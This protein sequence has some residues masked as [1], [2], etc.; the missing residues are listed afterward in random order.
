MNNK[1]RDAIHRVL[2]ITITIICITLAY[3]GLSAQSKGFND[4]VILKNGTVLN[5]VKAVVTKDSLVVTTSEGETSVFTKKEVSEVKKGGGGNGEKPVK[6]ETKANTSSGNWSDYQGYMNWE[7]AKKKCASIGMRLPTIEE[8]KAAY[9]AK[10]T[11]P[12]KTDGYSYWSSTTVD[13]DRAYDL[14]I[15]DGGSY[16][17]SRVGNLYVRCLR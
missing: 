8:L 6:I 3:T 10:V 15:D 7:D 1:R 16:D 13:D 2:K 12:W 5:G 11:A 14:R 9:V 17:Y 4:T